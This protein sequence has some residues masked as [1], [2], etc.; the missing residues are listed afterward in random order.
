MN[1]KIKTIP[2]PVKCVIKM[3]HLLLT[4]NSSLNFPIYF[5][6]S[7]SSMLSLC[8]PRRPRPHLSSLW[9][10]PVLSETTGRSLPSPYLSPLHPLRHQ[11]LEEEVKPC[12]EEQTG[13]VSC[14]DTGLYSPLLTPVREVVAR[15]SL[16]VTLHCD[17]GGGRAARSHSF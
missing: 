2:D 6:A 4:L 16:C 8:R 9:L 11:G 14:L 3:T 12:E 17:M 7:G 13:S 10:W 1:R 5:L 15:P